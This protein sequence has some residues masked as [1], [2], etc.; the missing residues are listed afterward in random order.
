MYDKAAEEMAHALEL[1]PD[2]TSARFQLGL[3]YLTSGRVKEAGSVWAGLDELGAENPLFLFKKGML[4]L[5]EDE[6]ALCVEAL[7]AGIELNSFNEDLNIDMRRVLVD[8]EKAMTK[9]M[10]GADVGPANGGKRMLLSLYECHEN[11]ES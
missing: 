9:G 5:V 3:L 11:D 7:R 8:A 2:L 10:D 1:E 4:H 6:F